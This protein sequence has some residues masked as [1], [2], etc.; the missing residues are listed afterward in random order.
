MELII[1]AIFQAQA[2]VLTPPSLCP[3]FLPIRLLQSS[4]NGND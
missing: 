3:T 2:N 1:L 4:Q